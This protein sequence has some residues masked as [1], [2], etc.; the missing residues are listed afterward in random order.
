MKVSIILTDKITENISNLASQYK[1]EAKDGQFLYSQE[2]ST[3]YIGTKY[4]ANPVEINDFD[5]TLYY[6]LGKQVISN[7]PKAVTD[8]LIIKSSI[9]QLC[10]E[11]FVLGIKSSLFSFTYLDK[12][13]IKEVT[14]KSES[15]FDEKKVNSILEGIYFT[16]KVIDMNPY[17]LNPTS[18]TKLLEQEFKKIPK[19]VTIKILNNKDLEKLGMN[20]ITAVGRGSKHGSNL[21][22]IEINPKN[23]PVSTHV[24]IGKGLTFDTGGVNIK[25]NGA[26]FGMQDDMGG[27]ATVFGIAKTLTQLEQTIDKKIVILAGL[28]ENVTDGNSFMPGEILE[29]IAGQTSI[30]KNTDAEGRLTLSDVVAY[31]NIKYKPDEIITLATL[32]GAAIASFTQFSAPL[33]SNNK[34]MRAKVYNSFLLAE[35]DAIEVDMPSKV[36]REGIKDSTGR[37]DMSNTGSYASMMGIRSAGSQTAASFV[38]ASAQASLYKKNKEGLN[39]TTKIVHIDIAGTAVDSKGNGS[40]YGVNSLVRYFVD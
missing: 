10:L 7:I 9:N 8:V 35:E 6:S 19:Y 29:N 33:F 37:S 11:N 17:E 16:K 12:Q 21:F 38:I 15:K 27:S 31:A 14:V 22:I 4:E 23:K 28:V 34:A 3:L 30:V 32:T 13:K 26:S 5:K 36:Y 2:T 40:G 25:E 18:Y 39:P 1:F 20:M 24:L